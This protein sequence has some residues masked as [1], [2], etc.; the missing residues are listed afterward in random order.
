MHGIITFMVNISVYD[1]I[2]IF[3]NNQCIFLS[4]T[5]LVNNKTD[6]KLAILTTITSSIVF[7]TNKEPNP[8]NKRNW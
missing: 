3:M 1:E 2:H 7:N 4:K 5:Y 6:Y 8:P